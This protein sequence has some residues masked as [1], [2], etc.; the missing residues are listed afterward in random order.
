MTLAHKYDYRRTL[1]HLQK[2]NRPLFVTFNSLHRWQLPEHVRNIVLE[3][4]LRE[5]EKTID[6]HCVVVMPDHVHMMFTALRD[7]EEWTY[8]LPEILHSIKGS[9]AHAINKA[10]RRSGPVW[11]SEFFDHVLRS[12][13]S[14]CEK[15]DYICQNPVRAG[16]VMEEAEYP[17]LWRGRVPVI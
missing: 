4:C 6:L 12:N 15:V 3:S 8:S 16:L 2:G 9:S 11:Q 17:W 7:Q 14:L 13:D 1:P 10:L 5:H